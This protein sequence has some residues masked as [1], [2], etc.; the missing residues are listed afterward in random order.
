MVRCGSLLWA[1]VFVAD[2]TVGVKV[3]SCRRQPGADG[4]AYV[5]IIGMYKGTCV[6][7]TCSSYNDFRVMLMLGCSIHVPER[8]TRLHIRA[9]QRNGMTILGNCAIHTR[10]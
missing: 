4:A 5:H 10:C 2:V 6:C 8:V 9:S 7:R 1:N 3:Y